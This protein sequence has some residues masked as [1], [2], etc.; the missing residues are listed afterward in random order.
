MAPSPL[1]SGFAG[2]RRRPGWTALRLGLLSVAAAVIAVPL[3]WMLLASLRPQAEI[4][5]GAAQLSWD[6]FLPS[7]LSA[8]NWHALAAGDFPRAVLNSA[9]VSAAT[10]VL[11]LVVNSLAGF[12]FAVFRFPF[13][14]TLLGLCIASFLMPFEATVLPLFVIVRALGWLDSYAAL[15]LPE[16][17]N[18][19][20]ILLFRQFFAAI[21]RDYFEAAQIDGAGWLRTWWSLALPLAWPTVATGALVLFLSQWDAFFWPVVAAP[22]NSMA[23]VQVAIARNIN[24]EQSDWGGLFASTSLAIMLGMIPFLLLQRFYVQS[25]TESGLK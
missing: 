11:G 8:A 4:F 10:V 15:I 7:T 6:T 22:S 5:R 17:A 1:V 2:E 13:R 18:G 14:R 19:M 3:A 24:F 25:V 9:I 23:V 12:A 21:P 20:V 16:V